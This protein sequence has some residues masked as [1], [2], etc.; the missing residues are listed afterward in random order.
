MR[1]ILVT[2]GTGFIG[3]HT[4][5][6]LLD[7]GY[8]VIIVDNLSN[9]NPSVLQK[10]EMITG[11][12]P[13]FYQCDITD[14]NALS[15]VFASHDIHT[16]IHFAGLKAV[17]ESVAEPLKYYYNNV[18]GSTILLQVMEKYNVH[19][20]IFSSSAT[21]YGGNNP[22][23]LTESSP[24]G[25][26]N[27]YGM[28]KLAVENICIDLCNSDP[29]WHVALLR[30]F[31]PVGAHMSGLIGEDPLGIPNNLFPILTQVAIGKRNM[32][33][34]F[35]ND[36]PTPDG[37]GVRDY[38]HVVDLALGHIKTLSYLEENSGT[39]I[40]NLGTG[41]GYSV[42]EVINTFEK[43]NSLKV[44]HMISPRRA[45]DVAECYSNP[46][47]ANELLQW[48]AELGLE[49]MCRDGWRFQQQNPPSQD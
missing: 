24:T 27:P 12:S 49:D 35:G 19:R 39:H 4:V 1:N 10:I 21:V 38:I 6:E 8:N 23:P 47:K 48:K 41:R 18:L 29:K 33:S 25:P 9:S 22:M 17:A 5:V 28:T 20:L 31:N 3:S 16:V 13:V 7:L 40:F 34:V 44:P 45:G 32:L 30:Y 43:V 2:G 14:S 15:D 37:T 46:S 42:L 26:V 11:K 36:Y